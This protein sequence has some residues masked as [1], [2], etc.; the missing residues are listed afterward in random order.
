MM[1]PYNT[2]MTDRARA[3]GRRS[4]LSCMMWLGLFLLTPI[5]LVA[6]CTAVRG[7]HPRWVH[8]SVEGTVVDARTGEPIE[9]ATVAFVRSR[10]GGGATRTDEEGRYRLD[11]VTE[12][13]WFSLPG[14]PYYATFVRASARGYVPVEHE[15]G[16]STGE[17]VGSRPAPRRYIEFQLNE[18]SLGIAVEYT[19]MHDGKLVPRDEVP[20]GLEP[21]VGPESNGTSSP[22]GQ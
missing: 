11:P 16:H 21:A 9:N 7:R 6:A 5:G 20:H 1:N 2:A 14:D 19:L 12:L 8:P 3:A 10:F 17:V 13:R 15:T 22:P 4:P 18:N